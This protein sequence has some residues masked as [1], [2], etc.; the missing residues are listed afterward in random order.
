LANRE[1]TV[2]KAYLQLDTWIFALCSLLYTCVV[3]ALLSCLALGFAASVVFL[4]FMLPRVSVY[5]FIV[6]LSI[7]V[8][9]LPV[10]LK[11]L[12]QL[13]FS[14]VFP[15]GVTQS[16]ASTK[17]KLTLFPWEEVLCLVGKEPETLSEERLRSV[18]LE[19]FA[20]LPRFKEVS[21][22]LKQQVLT[23]KSARHL[24][25][26][27]YWPAENVEVNWQTL[28]NANSEGKFWRVTLKSR[29]S[30]LFPTLM[31]GG[32]NRQNVLALLQALQGAGLQ[33]ALLEA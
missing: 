14:I 7:T 4:L 28:P 31:D 13:P 12:A 1:V 15:E 19:G 5:G 25:L 11:A 27:L 8:L 17:K 22:K 23:A 30:L 9:G 2:L 6:A 33:V 29:V 21:L 24:G 3:L 32:R 26:G 18:L 16:E 20:S 10:H